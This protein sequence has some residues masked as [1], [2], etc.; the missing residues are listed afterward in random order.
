MTRANLDIL[1]KSETDLILRLSDDLISK[2]FIAGNTVIISVSADYSNI[3]GQILRHSLSYKGEICDGF[4]IDVPY[5]DEVW[6]STYLR[7]L[8]S[9]MSLYRYKL[10]NKKIL[11]VEAGVIRGS[12]YKFIINYFKTNL[13]ITQDIYTLALYENSSSKFKSDFVG[14]YYDDETQDLTFWWELYNKHWT[15]D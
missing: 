12:N 3:I 4:S 10:N 8:E 2:N 1:Q 9:L 6:D 14:E 11:L 13:R 7:E 15:N 5:P